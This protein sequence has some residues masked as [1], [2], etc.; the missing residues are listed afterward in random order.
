MKKIYSEH[1][2]I[3][4]NGI[5]WFVVSGMLLYLQPFRGRFKGLEWFVTTIMGILLGFLIAW[6]YSHSMRLRIEKLEGDF[7]EEG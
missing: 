7:H 3:V 2:L 4:F 5:C 6:L 1:F